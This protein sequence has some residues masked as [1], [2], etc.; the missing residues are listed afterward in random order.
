[1]MRK[2]LALSLAAGM[3]AFTT[4]CPSK[5]KTT[6]TETTTGSGTDQKASLELAPPGDVKI[7]QGGEAPVHVKVTRK[8]TNEDI[9]V[10]FSDLPEGVKVK[11]EST[12]ITGG[13]GDGKFTL[14]A[15]ADAKETKDKAAK[16]TVTDKT[17]KLTAHQSF[18]VTV[19][20][21]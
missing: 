20:P 12:A 8:N 1:M 7:K 2:L 10:K 5:D 4:G 13:E 19:Q 21:K 6:K 3:L 11:E 9:T 14:V 15:T 18:K 16:V 17:G